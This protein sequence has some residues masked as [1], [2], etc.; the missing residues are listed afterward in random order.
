MELHRHIFLHINAVGC[1]GR[2][3]EERRYCHP[4][5]WSVHHRRISEHKT[6]GLIKRPARQIVKMAL[7]RGCHIEQSDF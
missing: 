1:A 5:N 3:L 2:I 6:T 4:P 7:G